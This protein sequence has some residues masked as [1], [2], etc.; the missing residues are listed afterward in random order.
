[1]GGEQGEGGSL[2]SLLSPTLHAHVINTPQ[3]VSHVSGISDLT[4]VHSSV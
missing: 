4:D 3:R 1:M 2:L